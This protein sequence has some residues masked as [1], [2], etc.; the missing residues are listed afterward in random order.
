MVY[1]CFGPGGLQHG[2]GKR[3]GCSRTVSDCKPGGVEAAELAQGRPAKLGKTA[4]ELARSGG[5]PGGYY[6]SW[7]VENA[8]RAVVLSGEDPR[9]AMLDYVRVINE[10]ITVKRKE[11]GLTVREEP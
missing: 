4:A 6:T 3:A 8:F 10:E 1:Q 2:A 5:S 11:L 7:H 9:E